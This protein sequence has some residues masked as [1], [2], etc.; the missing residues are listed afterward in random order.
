MLEST[1][2]QGPAWAPAER[3]PAV[4][5]HGVLGIP[6]FRFHADGRQ[7][8]VV[9]AWR[10]VGPTGA[11]VVAALGGISAGRDACDPEDPACGWWRELAGPSLPLDTDRYGVLAID[12]LGGAG[13][14][15]SPGPGQ[16]GFPAVD[17]RDQARALLAV[18]D[19][20]GIARLH[21]AAGASYGGMVALALAEI[22]PA[23]VGTV[24]AISTSHRSN[25]L[26]AAWRG[27][28]RAIVRHGLA[29]G[30][31]T[32]ALA[33]ARA[34]AMTTYRTRVELERR[35]P[36]GAA[37][38]PSA[39]EQY[40]R[41]RGE[42]YAG[43][44]RPEAFLCLSES[45]DGFRLDPAGVRVPVHL[46]AIAEDQLVTLAEVRELAAR[47]G[48]PAVLHELH[49]EYGHDAFLKERELLAPAFRAALEG[50]VT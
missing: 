13:A 6:R 17:A 38:H 29:L 42:A 27:I 34:L 2:L 16:D 37:A 12:W 3:P 18:C 25:A 28:Q 31:G 19:R 22:A 15:T 1:A 50:E 10:L 14:S 44:T 48:G 46:V 35:F 20:L 43:T 45:I 11:P 40:L 5:S 36:V 23:R 24:L 33:L 49:S 47:L 39:V 26:A 32:G 21:V 4:V 9:V 7:E 8:R 41:A 30:D